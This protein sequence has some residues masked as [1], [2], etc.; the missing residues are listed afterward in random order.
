MGRTSLVLGTL[1][2]LAALAALAGRPLPGAAAAGGRIA[3][4]Y[5]VGYSAESLASFRANASLL[6]VISPHWYT[7]DGAGAVC[8]CGEARDANRDEVVR[9]P[10][11]ALRFRAPADWQSAG[12]EPAPRSPALPPGETGALA[13]APRAAARKPPT[14]ARTVWLLREGK[15]VTASVTTGLTDGSMTELL[16][17]D[18]APG[19]AVV[20]D[21]K[22][23]GSRP[24][25][26]RPMP[27]F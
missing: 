27:L 10:N 20:T 4:A 12:A 17:G 19:D 6:Q 14:K 15:L 13:G 24:G 1:A 25:G 3:W 7:I 23:A 2:L 26:G 8:G 5:H 22:T 16:E 9:I 18:V 11:A 21:L